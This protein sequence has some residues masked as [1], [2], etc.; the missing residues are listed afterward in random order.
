MTLGLAPLQKER[1]R[2]WFSTVSMVYTYGLMFNLAGLNYSAYTDLGL[3]Y[4]F[5]K[6]ISTTSLKLLAMNP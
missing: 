6:S 5:K 2:V 1:S 4:Y 3:A